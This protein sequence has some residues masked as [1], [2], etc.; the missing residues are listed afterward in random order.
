MWRFP[1]S[2]LVRCVCTVCHHLCTRCCTRRACCCQN[3]QRL[4]N[5]TDAGNAVECFIYLTLLQLSC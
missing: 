1:W 5:K 4:S 2:P 3:S